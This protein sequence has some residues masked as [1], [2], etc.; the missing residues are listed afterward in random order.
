M[1][2]N[3]DNPSNS[4]KPNLLKRRGAIK[5]IAV[6]TATAV[7]LGSV[8]E[9]QASSTSPDAK[10]FT[11]P[12]HIQ[13]SDPLNAIKQKESEI[14]SNR[15]SVNDAKEIIKLDAAWLA[16]RTDGI[17]ANPEHAAER[18]FILTYGPDVVTRPE[19]DASIK[20]EDHPVVINF[21]KD[22]PDQ[23]YIGFFAK[24]LIDLY[25]NGF[26]GSSPQGFDGA[27]LNLDA[28]NNPSGFTKNSKP[29]FQHQAESEDPL[30][31]P[32]TPVTLFRTADIH[33][34]FHTFTNSGT[35]LSPEIT[36]YIARN[37]R[38]N[39]AELKVSGHIENFLVITELKMGSTPPVGSIEAAFNEYVSQ[40]QTYDLCAEGQLSQAIFH[41][42]TPQ[43]HRNFKTVLDQSGINRVTL[44]NYFKDHMLSELYQSIAMGAQRSETDKTKLFN[45]QNKVD[46]M[47]DFSASAFHWGR[48]PKWTPHI[49]QFFPGTRILQAG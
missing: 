46:D 47:I 33:E 39:P 1:D 31:S 11:P 42:V 12:A 7:G 34:K 48:I 43:E 25:Y 2:R 26:I 24:R 49:Q 16:T 20:I 10:T 22:H 32:L 6:A 9:V 21:Y 4:L 35:P 14:G 8:T 37:Y 19:K 30:M 27:F 5:L 15:L 40:A 18:T 3:K 28:A 45:N 36:S 29:Q 23:P 38:G 41:G 17:L 44:F 13:N